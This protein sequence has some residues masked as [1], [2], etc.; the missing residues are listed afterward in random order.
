MYV[1][2]PL[3]TYVDTH[4]HEYIYIYIYTCTH[5][6]RYVPRPP[7]QERSCTIVLR[8]ITDRMD[9]VQTYD[10]Q[11]ADS[12]PKS[13]ALPRR[14][15]GR[16]WS[17]PAPF[18]NPAKAPVVILPTASPHRPKFGQPSAMMPPLPPGSYTQGYPSAPSVA[19]S[20][21]VGILANTLLQGLQQLQQE[22]VAYGEAAQ[23]SVHATE[24]RAQQEI[25]EQEA[26]EAAA[27]EA[28]EEEAAAA[29][30][31]AVL[32]EARQAVL[33]ERAATIQARLRTSRLCAEAA[34]R[35]SRQA[36]AAERR[37]LV[38][39]TRAAVMPPPPTPPTPCVRPI[40]PMP[41]PPALPSQEPGSD[42]A[43]AAAGGPRSL[44]LSLSCSLSVP[45][46]SMYVCIY[47]H[48]FIY[49]YI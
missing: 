18:S 43:I 48:I 33:T 15:Q 1:Y 31:A 27:A 10:P 5:I 25:M 4:V 9:W 30:A 26:A 46:L 34:E 44:S 39:A 13:A 3:D 47:M 6:H 49:I 20:P 24:L 21:T 16:A 22:A 12:R 32:E 17:L 41:L 40:G 29:A 37:A 11:Y 8:W 35:R 38:R 2:R 19:L 28:Q 23:A 14:P 7:V 45:S 42:E 36:A